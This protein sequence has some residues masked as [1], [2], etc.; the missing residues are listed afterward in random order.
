MYSKLLLQQTSENP[1]KTYK[2]INVHA[3]SKY[4]VL[5]ESSINQEDI[6]HNLV[7][8]NVCWP[9]P[10]NQQITHCQKSM[11][12]HDTHRCTTFH[13]L[14]PIDTQLKIYQSQTSITL[15]ISSTITCCNSGWGIAGAYDKVTSFMWFMT[16]T[17]GHACTNPQKYQTINWRFIQNV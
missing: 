4:I 11:M 16:S 6:S 5:A 1:V 14:K 17:N 2:Y 8:Y 12:L 10:S 3:C 13:R 15:P 7:L 9:L